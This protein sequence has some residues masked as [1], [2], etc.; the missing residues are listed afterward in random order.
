MVYWD[1][2]TA[3]YAYLTAQK[4]NMRYAVMGYGGLGTTKSGAGGVPPVES[5]YPYYSDNRPMESL[6]ADIIVINHGTNDRNSDRKEFSEAYYS[7]LKSVRE[8][9][10]DSKIISLTPFSGCLADEINE[11]VTKYNKDY[12]DNI[13]YI[14]STGWIE[15][16]PL[17]PTRSSHKIIA[18]NLSKIIKEKFAEEIQ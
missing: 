10:P 8:R 16:E 4:L 15:K 17:H 7:F 14:N 9:N 2:S 6:N 1:D 3:G 12:S 11:I 13:F 5:S 18:E